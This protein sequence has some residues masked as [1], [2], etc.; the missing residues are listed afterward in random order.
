MRRNAPNSRQRR[1]AVALPAPP[2]P[3]AAG[4]PWAEA[5]GDDPAPGPAAPKARDALLGVRL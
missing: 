3:L 1:P 4:D 2:A 5:P